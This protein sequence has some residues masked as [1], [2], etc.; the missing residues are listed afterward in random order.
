MSKNNLHPH[1][2]NLS[3]PDDYVFENGGRDY[4]LKSFNLDEISILKKCKNIL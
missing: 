4:L 3:L 1:I 2:L